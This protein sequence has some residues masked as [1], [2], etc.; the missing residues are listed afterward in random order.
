MRLTDW[1]RLILAERKRPPDLMFDSITEGLS[2]SL[3]CGTTA[4]GDIVGGA[5][6]NT[7]YPIR[8][9]PSCLLFF[10]V[11]GFSLARA[12]SVLNS[13]A[14]RLDAVLV[15]PATSLGISP[16]APYT[17][18]PFL[19]NQLVALARQRQLPL[20]MHLAE[21]ADELGL[22]RNGT[23]PFQELLD[24][25]SMWDPHVIPRGSGPLDYLRLL[26]EVPRSLVVHGNYLA[27]D[28]HAFLAAHADR[29]SLVYCPRTHAY[30]GHPPYP[31]AKLLAAGVRVALGTDSRAS[32]PDLDLLAEMRQAAQAHPTVDPLA[33]L[34][35]GTLNGAWALGRH[36]DLGSLTP[37][38]RADLV[39]IPLPDDASGTPRDLLSGLLAASTGPRRIW[40][41]GEEILATA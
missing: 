9:V 36:G 25:R 11:I 7:S 39:A 38:K 35:M 31:L 13:L 29:M 27:T 26:A 8:P 19:L 16:H 24:E 21:S 4:I 12:D 6:Y 18:S 33:I 5:D 34:Q 3:A 37:G 20:A 23:G 14:G 22:L 41:R 1:I 17:V 40:Q 10:E 30:F 2:E 32:N 15:S 28:E